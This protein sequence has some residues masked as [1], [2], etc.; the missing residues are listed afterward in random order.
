MS[1]TQQTIDVIRRLGGEYKYGFVTDVE[2]E[3]A[4][5]GLSEDTIRFISAKKNEPDWLLDWRM[6]AFKAWMAAPESEPRWARVSYPKIDY[7]DM[8]YYAAPK[9]QRGPQSLDEVDPELLKTY[10]K[11]GIPLKERAAL[12]GVAVDAVFDSI[13]VATTF[14]DR[15]AKLGIVFCPISEAVQTHPSSCA[16]ISAASC[17]TATTSSPPSIRRSSA[18]APSSMC[19]RGSA[20]PWSSPPIS[21]STPRAAASSSARSSSPIRALM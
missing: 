18:T 13:S 14:K 10:E 11:L 21:V 12:A 16:N 5:K 17:P 8:Y 9:R 15:L 2:A 4:P 1:A 3:L 19:R 7:Q 20:A 6:K